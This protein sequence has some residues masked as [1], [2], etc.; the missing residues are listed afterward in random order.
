MALFPDYNG[1]YNIFTYMGWQLITD[2]S[3]LQYKLREESGQVFDGEGFGTVNGRWAI[4]CT[5]TFGAVGDYVDFYMDN[6]IVFESCIADIKSSGD[7]N[8]TIWGHVSGGGLSV[9]EFVVDRNTWYPSHANPGTPGCHP[10]WQGK[11]VKAEPRGNFW[12]GEEGVDMANVI[13]INAT[14]ANGNENAY[15]GT[16]GDDGFVYFNDSMFY[17][18]KPEGIWEQNLYVLNRTRHSWT[19][20]TIFTKLSAENLN[21]GGGSVAPGGSGV[22]AAVQWMIDIANDDS[23]GYDQGNRWGPDYDCSS[24]IYEAFR[25]AGGFD[26]PVQVGYTGTMVNDFEAAGF[27]WFPGQ[28]N[29]SSELVR[30]DILLNIAAHTEVYIGENMNVGAHSN[31]FGGI[32]GGQSGDQSGSEISTGGYYSFPWDGFLRKVS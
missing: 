23:H 12:T 2:P 15:V 9:L 17:R 7:P 29:A 21:S 3:S 18:F 4:A 24:L 11:V 14:K 19:K 32:L 8:W 20:S 27:T 30:G 26:L 31:E 5:E 28:G 22:E 1:Y 16:K 13:I 25:V 6:G 10:E